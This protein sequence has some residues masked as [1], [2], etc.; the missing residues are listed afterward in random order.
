MES[1]SPSSI[2]HPHH[3][4]D[5]GGGAEKNCDITCLLS[6]LS[7]T[8][9]TAKERYS[10]PQNGEISGQSRVFPYRE[11]HSDGEESDNDRTPARMTIRE[12]EKE[13]VNEKVGLIDATKEHSQ[14]QKAVVKEEPLGKEV[15][16]E[17]ALPPPQSNVP[18]EHSQGGPSIVTFL[19]STF[20]SSS[21]S[22][23]PPTPTSSSS[24][25]SSSSFAPHS[26]SLLP[27]EPEPQTA[28]APIFT[29]PLGFIATTPSKATPISVASMTFPEISLPDHIVKEGEERRKMGKTMTIT[30][31]CAELRKE[32]NLTDDK[33]H[34]EIHNHACN[35]LKVKQTGH[36][37]EDLISAFAACPSYFYSLKQQQQRGSPSRRITQ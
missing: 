25:S 33:K 24:S 29:N 23:H 14:H 4:S 5:V 21:T 16:T 17:K 19:S 7:L 8:D 22:T 6:L 37:K 2:H 32:L 26:T 1:K 27:P 35:L 12:A 36:L 11:P 3:S 31:L 30:A 10:P 9:L 15:H 28:S 18:Q 13:K 34:A 20:S